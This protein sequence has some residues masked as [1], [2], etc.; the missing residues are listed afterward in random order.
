MSAS[1]PRESRRLARLDELR[2]LPSRQ[3]VFEAGDRA[4]SEQRAQAVGV[5]RCDRDLLEPRRA[6][7]SHR[8]PSF[9]SSCSGGPD[10]GSATIAIARPRSARHHPDIALRASAQ[11]MRSAHRAPP[12]PTASCGVTSAWRRSSFSPSRRTLAAACLGRPNQIGDLR[13]L[14]LA[15]LGQLELR[16]VP[17]ARVSE[18]H[19]RT[20]QQQGKDR[21]EHDREGPGHVGHASHQRHRRPPF[22]THARP[23]YASRTRGK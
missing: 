8:C 13:P 3:G 5:Q 4:R 2:A 9:W 6:S 10:R 1:K 20:D 18:P 23:R 14:R 12:A 11:S 17:V 15:V 16:F 19:N 7:V 21:Q 22:Q